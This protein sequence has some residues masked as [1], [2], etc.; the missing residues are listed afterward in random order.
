[1]KQKLPNFKETFL[2][3]PDICDEIRDSLITHELTLECIDDALVYTSYTGPFND[4][5]R[6][7]QTST[8]EEYIAAIPLPS[9]DLIID[10]WN[11][12]QKKQ[13]KKLEIEFSIWLL[14][15]NH[16]MLWKTFNSKYEA[17]I[18]ANIL[19]SKSNAL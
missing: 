19:G 15:N 6:F 16:G 9:E 4:K 17:E 14:K 1:M 10:T 12:V 7:S 18:M 5:P 11:W 8:V 3:D 13:D 2:F